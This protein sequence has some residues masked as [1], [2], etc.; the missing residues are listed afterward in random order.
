MP[1]HGVVWRW[2]FDELERAAI[3]LSAR[4]KRGRVDM[5]DIHRVAHHFTMTQAHGRA[6]RGALLRRGYIEVVDTTKP[7]K[8]GYRMKGSDGEQAQRPAPVAD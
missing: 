5:F 7:H 3:L 6:L 1:R 4:A 8:Y 2:S